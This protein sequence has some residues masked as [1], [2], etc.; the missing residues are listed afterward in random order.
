M[1]APAG[2]GRHAVRTAVGATALVAIL[3]V[4][5]F[6]SIDTVVNHNL[7]ASAQDRLENAITTLRAEATQVPFGEPDIDDPVVGW[8]VDTHGH[9][10]G[11]SLGAP[12][13][14][15]AATTV[16]AAQAITIGGTD[17]LIAGTSVA[18]GRIIVAESLTSVGRALNTL[19][20]AEAIVAPVLLIIVFA[21]ALLV[22]RHATRPLE[23]A[24]RQQLEFTADASHELRT[25]LSVIEAE[26]SLALSNPRDATADAQVLHR[27]LAESQR[28]RGMVDDMLWLA[29]FDGSPQQ[30]PHESVDLGSSVSAAARRFRTVAE[31]R[32]IR[33]ECS[34]SS[35]TPLLIHA[36]AEWIDRLIGVLLDNACRYSPAGGRVR[37]TAAGDGS[38]AR[39]VVE[40][41]GPGIPSER[42]ERIFDRFHREADD[43]EGA[44]LGLAIG[45]AV[46]RATRGRWEIGDASLGGASF[47]VVWARSGDQQIPVP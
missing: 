13:L 23:R 11:A 35:V 34:E 25:P 18:G 43:G 41:T 29:R 38:H 40:D 24:H 47:A 15:A 12:P 37:V 32:S 3:L 20:I 6:V 42:R 14:P 39:L 1:T 19:I 46:V 5:L 33:L 22:A 30:P 31:R 4:V 9:L 10:T 26:T 27:V 45:D 7:R 17:F 8:R 28:M 2:Y 16:T 44:G 21:G 36:P